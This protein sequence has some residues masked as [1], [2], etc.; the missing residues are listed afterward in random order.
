MARNILLISIGKRTDCAVK[1]QQ[2]LTSDGCVIKTRIGLHGSNSAECKNN[3][4]IILELEGT[5]KDMSGL[6][7]KL[8][9]LKC[10]KTKFIS[11]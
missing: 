10:V 5:R 11:M 1:V 6:E 9:I 4:L 8:K 3:G 2:I 7:K